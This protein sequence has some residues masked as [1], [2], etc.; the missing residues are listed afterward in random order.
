MFGRT[1]KVECPGCGGIVTHK[2]PFK[3]DTHSL[4]EGVKCALVYEQFGDDYYDSGFHFLLLYNKSEESKKF[5]LYVNGKPEY[6][7]M[8]IEKK[9]YIF[10]G[11]DDVFTIMTK[12]GEYSGDTAASKISKNIIPVLILDEKILKD[13]DI[14]VFKITYGSGDPT[15][16]ILNKISQKF[17]LSDAKISGFPETLKKSFTSI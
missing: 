14:D 9:T 7:I 1:K 16:E 5:H 13:D 6:T 10:F 11:I 8:T 15:L 2:Y 17:L 4:D 3:K 12:V